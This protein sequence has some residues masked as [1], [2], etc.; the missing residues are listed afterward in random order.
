MIRVAPRTDFP[1]SGGRRKLIPPT[2]ISAI[3]NA[4]QGQAVQRLCVVET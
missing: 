1:K 3:N 4:A 2:E